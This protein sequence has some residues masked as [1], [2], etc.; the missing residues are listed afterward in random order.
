MKQSGVVQEWWYWKRRL[1]ITRPFHSIRRTVFIS[2]DSTGIACPLCRRKY[3]NTN[4]KLQEKEG[5]QLVR[6]FLS[7]SG[8][9]DAQISRAAF[10]VG[11][12]HTFADID[13]VDYQILIEADYIANA[14]ENGYSE[15][16]IRNFMRK[17]MKTSSGKKLLQNL[18]SNSDLNCC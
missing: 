16:N 3:G 4:G 6:E 9:T 2:S 14:S 8:M 12:H 1:S 15:E 7:G 18:F 11:H 13:N 17:M 10:L 5:E